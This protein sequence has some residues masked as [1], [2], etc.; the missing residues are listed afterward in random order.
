[1]EVLDS[2]EAVL[3]NFEVLSFLREERGQFKTKKKSGAVATVIL[4]SQT[5]LEATPAKDQTKEKVQVFMREMNQFNLTQSEKL[6]ILNH[7]PESAVEIHLF[8][9][10]SE[11]R[12]SEEQADAILKLVKTILKGE[13]CLLYT[14][15]SPRDRQKSRMPSSA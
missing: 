6:M 13:T 1:M 2:N 3:S 5:A 15:P 9:E 4:E 7:C 14:S 12:L 11:E 8:V 10:E